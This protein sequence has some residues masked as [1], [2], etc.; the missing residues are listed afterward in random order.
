MENHNN[1]LSNRYRQIAAQ[2]A[3]VDEKVP[4][5]KGSVGGFFS[6]PSKR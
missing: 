4:A 3:G 1:N 5:K 6:F 2:I